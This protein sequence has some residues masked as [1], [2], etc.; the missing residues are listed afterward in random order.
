MIRKKA[1]QR[2]VKYLQTK[3]PDEVAR[4]VKEKNLG[5][6]LGV[7]RQIKTLSEGGIEGATELVGDPRMK[8]GVSVRKFY[9]VENSP[10]ASIK[11]VLS[12]TKKQRILN[13]DPRTKD[14]FSKYVPGSLKI[15]PNKKVVSSNS[16]YVPDAPSEKYRVAIREQSK[17]KAQQVLGN[18]I[19]DIH[20]NVRSKTIDFLDRNSTRTYPEFTAMQKLKAGRDVPG[21]VEKGLKTHPKTKELYEASQRY[22]QLVQ[23]RKFDGDY[24]Y[25]KAGKDGD[26]TLDEFKNRSSKY[27][28]SKKSEDKEE[29]ILNLK[30]KFYEKK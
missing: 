18:N 12:K 17:E 1:K 3:T 9:D 10:V 5:E 8:D 15:A 29:I 19:A 14:L 23:A 16:E 21:R 11:S 13:K 6:A 28:R 24:D 22:P 27:L 2:L 4:I 7:N 30:K 26:I 25:G 20:G